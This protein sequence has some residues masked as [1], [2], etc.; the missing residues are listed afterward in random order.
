MAHELADIFSMDPHFDHYMRAVDDRGDGP[1]HAAACNGSVQC[2]RMLL[3]YG[4]EPDVANDQGL[5]P[6][7]LAARRGQDECERLLAEYHMHHSVTQ[8]GED[9]AGAFDSVLFLATLEGHRRCKREAQ[10]KAGGGGA[11]GAGGGSKAGI[12]AGGGPGGE[13][14]EEPYT[15]VK[16]P[17]NDRPALSRCE[18]LWSLRRHR[19]MRLEQWGDWIAYED[20][21]PATTTNGDGSVERGGEGEGK[22]GGGEDARP[23]AGGQADAAVEAGASDGMRGVSR[24]GGDEANA[25]LVFWYNTVTHEHQWSPPQA[26]IDMQVGE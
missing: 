20:V 21:M 8:A 24:K 2:V 16:R 10:A 6:I 4:L 5:R 18:S 1:L 25:G 22:P 14:G 15:I 19:S 23:G 7:D 11:W 12:R 3:Q 9:G 26:A 13:V 17:R